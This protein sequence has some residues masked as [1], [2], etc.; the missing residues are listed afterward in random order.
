MLVDASQVTV[1][2]YRYDPF[3]NP[4]SLSG[5]LAGANVYRFS[6]KE[7]HVNSGMYY[8][9]YRWYDPNLQR[10][11]NRDPIMELGGINLYGFVGNDP[12]DGCDLFGLQ[13]IGVFC[14]LSCEF[15]ARVPP[16]PRVPGLSY[17]PRGPFPPE[18]SIENPFRP[19]S[20]GRIDPQSGKFQECWRFDK[21]D[22]SK[23]GWGG[24]DHFHYW[25][26]PEHMAP[27]LPPFQW[28]TIP[29]V[30]GP[31]TRVIVPPGVKVPPGL[32]SP[33]STPPRRYVPGDIV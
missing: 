10:W 32:I 26:G 5:S 8:Y 7:I 23:P 14:R 25:G 4:I 27:P 18:G 15:G 30:N 17:P 13:G 2:S 33:P 20:W 31:P 21:G 3:G 29:P 1:A 19:G 22:P 12:V 11:L 9:G 24:I 16:V 6:S 28:F